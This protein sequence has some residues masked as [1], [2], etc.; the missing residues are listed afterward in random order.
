MKLF[1]RLLMITPVLA[2]GGLFFLRG[3]DG[4][5]AMTLR[6]IRLPQMQLPQW[7]EPIPERVE[8]P[9]NHSESSEP[10]TVYRWQDETGQWHFSDT[11]VEAAAQPV[12]VY[13]QA[14][15]IR[16]RRSVVE[17]RIPSDAGLSFTSVPL[18][19]AEMLLHEAKAMRAQLQR[20]LQDV[21]VQVEELAR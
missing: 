1:M 6:D 9:L 14:N 15:L 7:V 2:L 18:R 19:D 21:R 8:W 10:A 3:P 4:L 11:A 16:P 13:P 5:P 17:G 12:V 20:R